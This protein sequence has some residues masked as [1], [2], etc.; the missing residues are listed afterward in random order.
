MRVLKAFLL[1]FMWRADSHGVADFVIES[2]DVNANAD[3]EMSWPSD[4]PYS[5]VAGTDLSFLS[6]CL[7]R[8]CA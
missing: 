8:I 2:L 6:L 5:L 3:P 7:L 1:I 4:R